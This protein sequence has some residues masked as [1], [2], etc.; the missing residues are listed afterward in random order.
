TSIYPQSP[1][2][3]VPF[4]TWPLGV[5]SVANSEAGIAAYPNPATGVLKVE[6]GGTIGKDAG[7][8]LTDVTGKVV[9]VEGVSA[10]STT[11]NIS[12]L[13]SGIYMLK[14]RDDVRTETIKVTKQ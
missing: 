8:Q 13:P 11:L 14:Y 9:V 3:T 12:T 4:K 5:G 1:W 6:V 2:A 10:N 7:L